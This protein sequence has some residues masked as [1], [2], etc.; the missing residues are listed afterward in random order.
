MLEEMKEAL[1]ADPE[2]PFLQGHVEAL[3]NADLKL[4]DA[5][6]DAAMLVPLDQIED[7]I[8]W[9]DSYLKTL[10]ART[11]FDGHNV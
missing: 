4:R 10:K 11:L 6:S 8:K 7:A 2:N 9:T 3:E 5:A 1:A